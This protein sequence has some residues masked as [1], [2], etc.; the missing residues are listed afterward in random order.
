MERN[1]KIIAAQFSIFAIYMQ[2]MC[3]PTV[4]A[5]RKFDLCPSRNY[6]AAAVQIIHNLHLVLKKGDKNRKHIIYIVRVTSKLTIKVD[7]AIKMDFKNLNLLWLLY[8]EYRNE[9]IKIVQWTYS[10]TNFSSL[11][12]LFL[13]LEFS[14]H[15]GENTPSAVLFKIVREQSSSSRR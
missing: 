14:I 12:W 3:C 1:L 9:A 5:S 4:Y 10:V 15:L 8:K 2:F 11:L 7:T 6:F 13:D